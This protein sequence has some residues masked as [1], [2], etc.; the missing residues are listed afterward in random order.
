MADLV[1]A[2]PYDWTYDGAINPSKMALLIID[3]Q[4]DFCG[5]GGYVDLLGYDISQTAGS[6]LNVS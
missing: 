4:H 3:M 1:E 5:K 6:V 2:V